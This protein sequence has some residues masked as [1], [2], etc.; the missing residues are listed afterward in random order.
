MDTG[1]L[2]GVQCPVSLVQLRELRTWSG[3]P[4]WSGPAAVLRPPIKQPHLATSSLEVP[5]S[6]ARLWHRTDRDRIVNP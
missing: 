2:S 4:E 5:S 1:R 6:R 3:G